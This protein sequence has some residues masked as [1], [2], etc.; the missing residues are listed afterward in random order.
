LKSLND[1]A[2]LK[3]HIIKTKPEK[4]A[5]GKVKKYGHKSDLELGLKPGQIR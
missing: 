5:M 1:F 3:A 4:L 2:T